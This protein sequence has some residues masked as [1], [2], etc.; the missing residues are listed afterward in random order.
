MA[1]FLIGNYVDGTDPLVGET[2]EEKDDG[3][4]YGYLQIVRSVNGAFTEL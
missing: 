3:I 1:L 2:D 4:G